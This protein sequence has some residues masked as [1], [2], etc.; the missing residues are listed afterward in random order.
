MGR[1]PKRP[2]GQTELRI[3]LAA[4]ECFT[5]VGF[6]GATN[7]DIAAQ[8]DVTAAALYRYFSSKAELWLAVFHAAMADLT[9]RMLRA[10][11]DAEDTRAAL[12][13]LIEY[14][15]KST[16][17]ERV[18]ARFLSAVPDEM[19]RHPELKRRVLRDPG[20][21]YAVINRFVALGVEGGDVEPDK[22]QR[23]VSMSIAAF[24]GLSAYAKTLG[25]SYG[26]H[27]ALGFIDLLDGELFA[28]KKNAKT[29]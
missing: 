17:G 7:Q 3:L 9:P 4:R 24:M 29:R 5:R 20:E 28:A 18:A 13:G 10:L 23:V 12:R 19:Q 14:W 8:A 26:E 22:A 1:P 2:S 16:E 6:E 11:D 27:A 15:S 25:S 21:I